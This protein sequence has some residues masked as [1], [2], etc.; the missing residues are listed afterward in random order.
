[1]WDR[2]RFRDQDTFERDIQAISKGLEFLEKTKQSVDSHA[3]TQEE[4]DNLK[5]RVFRGV[6]DLIGLGVTLPLKG[7]TAAEERKRL[8]ERRSTKLLA[9]S[10]EVA[11]ADRPLSDPKL[12]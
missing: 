3:I 8:T 7:E 4:A 2:I 9:A 5:A 11:P 1:M 12:R 6:N 10:N